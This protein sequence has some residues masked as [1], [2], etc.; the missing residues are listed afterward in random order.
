MTR[1]ESDDVRFA[2]LMAREFPEGF[3]PQQRHS[4]THTDA[5]DETDGTTDPAAAEPVSA[6]VE[7]ES[8][9]GLR[10]WTPADEPDEPFEPPAAPPPRRWTGAGIA[11]TVLVSLPLALVLLVAFGVRVPAAV[12]V[13]AGAGLVVGVGL[14][15][16]RLRRRPPPEGDGAVL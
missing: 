10:S 16:Q 2:E 15:L 14:L 1:S 3:G 11:G 9:D 4:P 13:L 6:P 12:S 8:Q 5:P 7:P